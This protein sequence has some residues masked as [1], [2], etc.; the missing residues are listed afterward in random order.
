M[1]VSAR[2]INELGER[3]TQRERVYIDY[4]ELN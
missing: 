1:M 2:E 4:N 3:D